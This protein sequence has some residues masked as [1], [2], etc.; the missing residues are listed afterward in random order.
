[1]DAQ[2]LTSP[3]S[4]VGTVAY[5][6][7]EQVRGKELDARTDLFSFGVVLYEMST[8]AI[9]FR[10][11][12]SGVITDAILNRAPVAP[13]RLNPALPPKLEDII[14]K[15]IEKDRKLRYQ[16]AAEMAVDLRRLQREID[17]GRTGSVATSTSQ[18]SA[19]AA[20]VAA[21]ELP[22]TPG[23]RSRAKWLGLTAA[24][25]VVAAFAAYEF[26]PTLPPPRI[27]GYT[28]LTHDGFP[29]SFSGQAIANLQT[30]GSRIYIQENVAGHYVVAQV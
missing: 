30:D 24:I 15:A 17:S 21:A 9:P 5:M 4:A 12:T 8:G 16:S 27:T 2:N 13:V 18:T 11:E 19:V 10:G 26:R 3:G 23:P 29:K 7:P 25:V 28:Q 20:P 22:T 14:N 1:M 6:S